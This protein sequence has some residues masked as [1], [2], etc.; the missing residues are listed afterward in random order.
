MEAPAQ[1]VLVDVSLVESSRAHG[2]AHRGHRLRDVL[3]S[4]VREADVEH[5]AALVV[6][7]GGHDA[8]GGALEARGEEVELAEDLDAD[9]ARSD[10]VARR[11]LV[12]AALGEL[13]QERHLRVAAPEVVRAERVHAQAPHA[14]GEAPLEDLQELVRAVRVAELAAEVA[15]SREAAV[16]VHHDGDV[17]GDGAARTK[18][19]R[20]AAPEPSP[21]GP[22]GGPPGGGGE[23]GEGK[24]PHRTR[25]GARRGCE[26][27]RR[28][29]R[30]APRD[31]TTTPGRESIRGGSWSGAGEVRPARVARPTRRS[32]ERPRDYW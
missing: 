21:G 17:R 28:A 11:H 24:N 23:A 10:G 30:R 15:R 5:G 12:Q 16:A 26:D 1:D 27:A 32:G 3:A 19:R 18:H 2:V 31:E 20:D 29:T 8:R 22:P 4:G 13:E 14:E 6:P 9:A 7:R 25:V